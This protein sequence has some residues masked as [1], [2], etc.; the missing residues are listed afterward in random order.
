MKRFVALLVI[1]IGPGVA[2]GQ[3]DRP[4]LL[5][6][7][8]V[9]QTHIVFSFADDLWI[10]PRTGGDAQ[11]LTSGPG[12][13]TD[14]HFSPDGKWIAFTGEYEGNGDVYVIPA[15]GGEPRR[16]T[17]HPG[18]DRAVGW[19]PDGKN[20]LFYSQRN[21]YSRFGRLFTVP[22]EGGPATELPLPMAEQGMY[23]GDG[24][25]LAYGSSFGL[26]IWSS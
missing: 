19:T 8:A 12:V 13:E 11:R 15:T 21:S 14:P 9:N 3:A 20:V 24:T 6:K 18:N 17:F 2:L 1:L 22:V 26:G 16:L 7:P 4:L 25:R 5:Q 23:S 10:V